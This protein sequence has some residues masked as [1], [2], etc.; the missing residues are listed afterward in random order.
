MVQE[1]VTRGN[2]QIEG[3]IEVWIGTGRMYAGYDYDG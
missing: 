2:A 1:R 3:M